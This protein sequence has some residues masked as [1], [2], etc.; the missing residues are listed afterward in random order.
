M[1]CATWCGLYDPSNPRKK[2]RPQ[3][4]MMW[5]AF[6]RGEL[7]MVCVYRMNRL[8]R[9]PASGDFL[10]DHF[11]PHGLK[12]VISCT[13]N[14]DINTASGRFQ[15]AEFVASIRPASCDD[16]ALSATDVVSA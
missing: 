5:E 8:W 1:P 10:R 13:E 4:T 15:L 2:H 3:L 9:K 7:D 16:L 14:I 12:R 11:V 6:Q